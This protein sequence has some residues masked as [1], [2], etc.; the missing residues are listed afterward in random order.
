MEDS[1]EPFSREASMELVSHSTV[2]PNTTADKNSTLMATESNIED[3]DDLIGSVQ[4]MFGGQTPGLFEDLVSDLKKERD[5]WKTLA[6]EQTARVNVLEKRI[7]AKSAAALP[8]DSDVVARLNRL[9]QENRQNKS[10]NHKLEEEIRDLTRSQS[11]LHEAND[12]KSRQLRGASKKVK[13]AKDVAVK[14]KEKADDAFQQKQMRLKSEREIR[15]ELKDE[16]GKVSMCQKEIESLQAKLHIETT[17][18]PH[19]RDDG[20]TGN[21][22]TVAFTVQFLIYRQHFQELRMMLESNRMKMTDKLVEWYDQWKKP[23]EAKDG[24]VGANYVHS[25]KSQ[26]DMFEDGLEVLQEYPQTGAEHDGWRS[27]RAL[28]AVCR[29]AMGAHNAASD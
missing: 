25:R 7:A 16:K 21:E 14:E 1:F 9:E 22:A 24:V 27:K 6:E 11:V 17:G 15:K 8:A 19:I 3:P 26:T 20:T 23:E 4:T 13:N 28:E 5:Q 12:G 29:Q 18:Y 10:K 2:T